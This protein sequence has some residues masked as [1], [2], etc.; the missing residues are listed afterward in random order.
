M[1]LEQKKE[2]EFEETDEYYDYL[3]DKFA[4]TISRIYEIN[5]ADLVKLWSVSEEDLKAEIKER[6]ALLSFAR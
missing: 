4:A 6:E 3:M 1:T 5:K 2:A